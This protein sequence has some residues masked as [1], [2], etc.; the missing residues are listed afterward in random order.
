MANAAIPALL[1]RIQLLELPQRRIINLQ[2]PVIAPQPLYLLLVFLDDFIVSLLHLL[3]RLF[4]LPLALLC[5]LELLQQGLGSA[6]GRVQ[7]V[8]LLLFD[9][10]LDYGVFLSQLLLEFRVG[11]QQRGDGFLALLESS[12]DCGILVVLPEGGM[13]GIGVGATLRV[14]C[15][16]A[17]VKFELLIWD[18]IQQL[19]GVSA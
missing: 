1:L 13:G 8:L 4:E 2:R 14:L 9:Q 12:P 10:F 6:V 17:H 16:F 3:Q 19:L 7:H 18:I 15:E 5:G 11:V